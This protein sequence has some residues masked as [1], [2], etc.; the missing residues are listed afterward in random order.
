MSE[1]SQTID[2]EEEVKCGIHK[3][4]GHFGRWPGPSFYYWKFVLHLF[5]LHSPI[6]F[7]KMEPI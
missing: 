3:A 6:K 2:E 5:A 7:L 4:S 1:L